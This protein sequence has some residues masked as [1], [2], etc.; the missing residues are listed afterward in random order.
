MNIISF[1][2]VHYAT[3]D[4]ATRPKPRCTLPDFEPEENHMSVSGQMASQILPS[5]LREQLDRHSIT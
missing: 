1:D 5:A 2:Y 3:P 4:E